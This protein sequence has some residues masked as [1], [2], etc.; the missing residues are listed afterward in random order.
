MINIF[1]HYYYFTKKFLKFYLIDL[2]ENNTLF[3]LDTN[4]KSKDE[5]INNIDKM[6]DDVNFSE[7]EE[8][9]K[10]ELDEKTYLE[11]LKKIKKLYENPEEDDTGMNSYTGTKNEIIDSERKELP[12][13]FQINDNDVFTLCGYVTDIVEGKILMKSQNNSINN[14]VINLDNIIFNINKIPIGFIDDVMGQID[15]PIYIIRIYPNLIDQKIKININEELYLCSNKALIINTEEIKNK[16]KGCDA[17]NAFD[18][19]VSS[20]DMDYSDD[21]EEI[22]AKKIRKAKNLEIKKL[23]SEQ[24]NTLTQNISNIINP[25][26]STSNPLLFKQNMDNQMEIYNEIMDNVSNKNINPF[27]KPSSLNK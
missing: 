3:E 11:E 14:K 26:I 20:D 22:K 6:L 10:D 24:K 17:S 21:D 23:K 27:T 2:M 7:D 12:I 19:E 1:K 15:Y 4:K 8:K 25:N 16:H 9:E 13:P 5:S 18:E